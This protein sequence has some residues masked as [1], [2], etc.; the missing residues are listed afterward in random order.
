MTRFRV[1]LS[2]CLA[3][4][5][6]CPAMAQPFHFVALGDTAY[7]PPDDYPVYR[8]L[9]ETINST[10]PA[11]TIHV[12]DTWG[13]MDC[14]DAEHQRIRDFFAEYDHPVVYTPGDNEWVDCAK[15]EVIELGR[16]FLS[17]TP[18][19]EDIATVTAA[20]SLDGSFARTLSADGFSSLASIRKTFFATSKS[21]GAK[22]MELTRQ[23]DV[24]EFGD[25]VENALWTHQGVVFGTV[26]VT[27]TANNFFI[28]DQ[29]RAL[30]AITRNNA[31]VAWI[32]QIFAKAEESEAK[33]V[34][35][36][37][38]AALFMD[39]RD[40]EFT[41]ISVRGGATGPFYWTAWAIRDLGGEFGRPVLV[42]HGDFHEFE[43]D[44]PFMV[45][46]GETQPPQYANITRLQVYGSPEI[47]AV[48]VS[49]EPD[50]PWV[51]SFSPLHN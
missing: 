18:T 13:V 23:A 20:K 10:G 34:V 29:D 17:G 22:P 33:A 4:A 7:N 31:N 44:R 37:L 12:G 1:V 50:T 9:I 24:S 48:R 21:L 43:I 49:V 6:S 30:E 26:H 40:G 32:K 16:R 45:S 47:K 46:A 51:F 25:M 3:L 27:G 14:N 36:A 2:G 41:G 38:H 15:S 39:R 35:I 11:F 19:E 8:A 42:I 5:I 28:N